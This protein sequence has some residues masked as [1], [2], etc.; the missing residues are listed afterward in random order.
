MFAEIVI[1]SP[2]DKVFHYSIPENLLGRVVR[3][4]RVVVPFG[5]RSMV[6]YVIRTME[7]AGVDNTKPIVSVVEDDP[8]VTEELFAL[9]D[10]LSK[11]YICSLG[12]ALSTIAP[13]ALKPLKRNVTR[14]DEQYSLPARMEKPTFTPAQLKAEE[15]INGKI[16]SGEHQT[17]L[18]HGVTS[19]GKT[20]VYISAIE[21]TLAKGKS[22]V[23]LLPEIS[24]TPQF[25]SIMRQR[26][27]GAVGVWHSR[28][29]LGEKYETWDAARKGFVKIMLGARSALFAPFKKLG[30]II[31]DEEHEQ[32]YKQDQKPTYVTR[33]TA[34]RRAEIC[35]AVAVL[36]SA[37][38]SLETY[39]LARQGVYGLLELPE[40]VDDL[41]FPPVTIVDMKKEPKS[42]RVISRTMA[43]SLTKTLARREQAII[44]LNRRGFAP[45]VM[46]RSCGKVWECPDCSVSLVY[47]R[48]PEGLVCHYCGRKEPW[49]GTCPACKSTDIS[50][51]GVGTQ[52][53][54]E[55]LK[56]DFPQA[57]IFRLD[58]D[59]AAK[60]GAYKKAYE[61]FKD[62]SCDI[63]L[64]TQMVAKGFDFPRVT[65]VGVID[66]D[67]SLYLPEFR[68][69]ERTFQ[70][71][72]QV[73]GRSGRSRLG[74]EV[75][76]QTRH[77]EHY[78]LLAAGK[79]DYK[80]FY[81][82]EIAYRREMN[83]PPFTSLVNLLIRGKK[84]DKSEEASNNIGA[85][86]LEWQK[87]TGEKVEMLGPSQASKYKLSGMFRWQ[88]LLKG[89]AEALQAVA[90]EIRK[91]QV[92]PGILMTV[93]VD[94][95]NIL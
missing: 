48:S 84:E 21:R 80:Q 45:S 4:T 86:I 2:L 89:K 50:I 15:E 90:S 71:M 91:F 67:T 72:T 62:E 60:K 30:L 64:G 58:R 52:K 37:T 7:T 63:L 25:I 39:Y 31:M 14:V 83:Y 12:E 8:A 42:K 1:P 57:R 68:S 54:E 9:A 70:L 29:S 46:C 85:F 59:T 16:A 43:E 56:K 73:A 41:G 77:P 35:G 13:P 78:A 20:E 74:G 94:P 92:P 76:V 18:L 61:D 65:L 32:S 53:A 38:P 40:R 66:A 79:H 44:F 69:A 34:V 17:F 19:S 93:D 33:D 75:I 22:V 82:Q 24:L 23:F 5:P 36:G 3:G 6:G 10:W 88:I 27:P 28:L 47:H 11:K 95:Q 87:R 81:D 55:E 26:F 49:P 51:F